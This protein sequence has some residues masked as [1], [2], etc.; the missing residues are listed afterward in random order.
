MEFLEL[1]EAGHELVTTALRMAEKGILAPDELFQK[2]DAIALDLKKKLRSVE[3]EIKGLDADN[4]EPWR[5]SEYLR[6]RVG[7]DLECSC[8]LFIQQKATPEWWAI[9][10]WETECRNWFANLDSEIDQRQISMTNAGIADHVHGV[11]RVDEV[12]GGIM[13]D[14]Q[15]FALKPRGIEL[16]RILI[17]K[18]GEFIPLTDYGFRTRDIEA[19]PLKVQEVIE[20]QPGA[21]TRILPAWLN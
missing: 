20:S 8:K 19:L 11:K 1:W 13:I 15:L 21:G 3:S 18:K 4:W 12:A 10:K 14:G 16:V 17:D 2:L 9:E 5:S 7:S 6:I